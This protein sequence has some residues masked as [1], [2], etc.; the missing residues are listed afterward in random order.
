MPSPSKSSTIARQTCFGLV[1][2]YSTAATA[3]L[4]AP[5]LA[6][7]ATGSFTSQITIT[8]E[9]KVQSTN[10]LDFGTHGVL[11]ANVDASTVF[12]VQCTNGT[13]YNVGLNG[14]STSGGT[15]AT[16]LMTS[17]IATVNYHMYSNTGRT[18][19][20]GNTVGTDTVSGTGNG[21]TQSMTI[22]GRVPAQT[23]PAAGSYADTVTITVTY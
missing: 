11:D 3:A 7:T 21:A 23:T 10:P 13:T 12:S 1:L 5:V 6:A 4:G 17:G 15:V 14:G 8:A 2:A 22:Y 16:R 19:T 20:W 18:T 9:C